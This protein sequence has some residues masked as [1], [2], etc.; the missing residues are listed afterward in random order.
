M[1]FIFCAISSLLIIIIFRTQSVNTGQ[2]INFVE[3]HF[4][5]NADI[6]LWRAFECDTGFLIPFPNAEKTY[7]AGPLSAS[8]FPS[9]TK[10]SIFI[11]SPLEHASYWSK[12]TF[13]WI[14]PLIT[15]GNN[16][17]KAGKRME[18]TDLP[19]MPSEMPAAVSLA[20]T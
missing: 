11:A 4:R 2:D 13:S 20:G 7:L 17:A 6:S 10:K 18:M 1:K 12:M 5:G 8:Q 16:L 3:N 9:S 15:R 19:N 14:S